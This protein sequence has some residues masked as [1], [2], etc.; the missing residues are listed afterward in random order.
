MAIIKDFE[1]NFGITA[2]Y[3]K[4]LKVE[5]SSASRQIEL[6]VGIY[7][8][9]EA[10]DSGGMPIWNEYVRIPFENLNFDPRDIFYPLLQNYSLSYLK[11]GVPSVPSGVVPHPPVFELIE[12][13]A[14][15]TNN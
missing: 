13:P 8:S 6:V 14:V 9:E 4:L 2:R 1:T 7:V 11:N 5:V 15:P 10:R 12:T 3:H